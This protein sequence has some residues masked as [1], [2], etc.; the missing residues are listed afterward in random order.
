MVRQLRRRAA[1]LDGTFGAELTVDCSA[2]KTCELRAV[3]ARLKKEKVPGCDALPAEFWKALAISNDACAILLEMC[4][5]CWSSKSVPKQWRH[6]TVVALFKKEDTSLPCNYRPISL[7]TV[8]YKVLASLLLDRLKVTDVEERMHKAQFG[9][10]PKRGTSDAL[11][12]ARRMIDAAVED[13]TGELYI[14]LLDWSKAFD[15]SK[16]DS[17]LHALGRFGFPKPVLEMIAGIYH[18]RTFEVRDCGKLSATRAQQVGIAQGCPLSPYLFIIMMSVL[19][20]D[21]RPT[22][23][24]GGPAAKKY[25]VSTEIAYADDTMLVGSDA[26]GVQGHFESIVK[27]GRT[28]GLEINA[29]KTLLLRVRGTEDIRF[30][31]GS[32][33]QVN[34][35]LFPN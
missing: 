23:V 27:L 13:R 14:L 19:L 30:A 34:L 22:P 4:N 25:V 5:E 1:C 7:L 29:G 12:L 6:S 18:D 9:F 20:A 35:Y 8:G 11:F 26:G 21:A 3:L 2:F 16:H 17:L 33:V 15:K 24:V 32:A 28:Y 10:R 31:D